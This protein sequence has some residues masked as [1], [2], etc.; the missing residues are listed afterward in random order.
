[1]PRQGDPRKP[2]AVSPPPR[3]ATALRLPV[4]PRS[5]RDGGGDGKEAPGAFGEGA[6][7]STGRSIAPAINELERPSIARRESIGLLLDDALDLAGKRS[8]EDVPVA[9]IVAK[10]GDSRVAG[11]FARLPLAAAVMQR[12]DAA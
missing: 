7:A 11:Y 5:A 12:E 1:R 4:S 9:G 6:A 3:A 10:A 8:D 2:A